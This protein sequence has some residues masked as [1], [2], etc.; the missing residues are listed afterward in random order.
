[1]SSDQPSLRSKALKSVDQVLEKDPALLDRGTLVVANI[2]KCLSDPSSQVKESALGLLSKCMI[3]RRGLESL[4]YVQIANLAQDASIGVKKR[5]MRLLKDLY[6]RNED[7]NI[8]SVV[9]GALL[10]RINDDEDTVKDLA[11]LTLEEIWF[12]PLHALDSS[13]ASDALQSKL[14][15]QQQSSMLIG[16]I[17]QSESI[18][19]ILQDLLIQMMS[20]HSK[21][22][23]ENT[24]I[25]KDLVLAMVDAIISEDALP[26]EHKRPAVV[27]ALSIFAQAKPQLFTIAQLQ[28]L[29]PY[30]K[31]V[32]ATDNSNLY[33]YTIIIMR[34]TLPYMSNLPNALVEDMQSTLLQTLSRLPAAELKEVII[35]LWTLTS[36]LGNSGKLVTITRS[37]LDKFKSIMTSDSELTQ[38]A[39]VKT[40]LKLVLLI[41][42]FAATFELDEHIAQFREKFPA[43]KGDSLPVLALE[44]ITPLTLS[45]RPLAIR[46]SALDSVCRICNAHPRLYMRPDVCGAL[47]MAFQCPDDRLPLVLMD[48]L[49]GFFGPVADKKTVKTESS[50]QSAIQAGND[51]IVKTYVATDRDGASTSLAQTFLTDAIDIALKSTGKLALSSAQV[52][53]AI[54]QLGLVHPRESAPCL[55]ALQTSST[56]EIANMA[57]EEYKALFT[58]HESMYEKESVRAV[59]QAFAY[60]MRHANDSRGHVG[61]PA[62]AKLALFWDVMTIASAKTRKRFVTALCTR[63][64]F[65]PSKLEY[66]G[67]VPSHFYFSRFCLENLALFDYTKADDLLALVDGLERIVSATGTGIAHEIESVVGNNG[68]TQSGIE[69]QNS[70]LGSDTPQDANHEPPV[71]GNNTSTPD[72]LRRLGASAAILTLMWETRTYVSR[73]WSLSKYTSAQKRATSE[74]SRELA[75][76]PQR[77]PNSQPMTERYLARMSEIAQ[78]FA[79]P[80]ALIQICTEFGEIMSVD[81]EARAVDDGDGDIETATPVNGDESAIVDARMPFKDSLATPEK[82]GRKRKSMTPGDTP[83]K[84]RNLSKSRTSAAVKAKKR[85]SKARRSADV[86]DDEADEDFGA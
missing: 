20:K 75:R 64:E 6:L 3:M 70:Q 26:G 71:N 77:I 38:I 46:E 27:H 45:N 56:R 34:H 83:R 42:H 4:T 51:R 47:Q 25:A 7:P 17:Q 30:L 18:A 35:C 44:Q 21:A 22:H 63:L 53:V 16:T 65:T 48:S 19:P 15:L 41:G 12:T 68:Q 67:T 73:L 2:V 52:V 29:L 69:N 5:A 23:V 82:R 76:A 66:D 86:S 81:E 11:R 32:K 58:R 40:V 24:R 84:K 49:R 57:Y 59:Q 54:N 37:A 79:T 10:L 39:S 13:N 60:Q 55:V 28:P 85:M 1:M 62:I 9:S 61:S 14:L 78:C 43:Y 72:N 33:R 31:N 80:E 74:K 8:R 36:I 50:S